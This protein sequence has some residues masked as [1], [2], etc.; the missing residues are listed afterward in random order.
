MNSRIEVATVVTRMIAGAGGVALRGARGLDPARYRVTFVTGEGGP[1]TRAAEAAGMEVVL[2]PS[3]VP[4]LS[5][6]Q[7]LLAVRR[8]TELFAQRRFDVVHTH[9]AKAGAVGRVAAHRCS[10]PA[11]VHTYH[12]FPFHDFQGRARRQAYIAAERRL[13]AYTDVVLCI[14]TGVSS[15]A[16]RRGLV[17]DA[18]LRTVS[19]VV[20]SRTVPLTAASRAAA[21]RTL[22]LDDRDVVVGTVGRL[23]F[24]KAPEHFV[25]ALA[26]LRDPRVR[27]VWIGSGPLRAEVE[28]LVRRR[29]LQDRVLLAGE[30][31]DVADLLPAFDV[32]AMSSR[33]EGLPCAL[34]EAMRCGIPAV[35]TAVNSVPD[36]IIPGETGVLVRAGHPLELASGIRE[37]L[38]EPDRTAMMASKGRERAAGEYDEHRLGE[39]LDE[40]YSRALGLPSPAVAPSGSSAA[41]SH[42]NV[43]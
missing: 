21:R 42:R 39:I 41:P 33:Y 14:G 22:G 5:A 38:D 28:E 3:L 9:S 34:V 30:R 10:T 29:G 26:A 36:L 27:G 18:S 40:E 20:E 19:P 16:L 43:A 13:A 6:R 8:L 15:E 1:L 31:S 37:L 32:F 24:Q 12:G 11:I 23:D 4:Q 7:D 25:E 2:E 17:V 35:V